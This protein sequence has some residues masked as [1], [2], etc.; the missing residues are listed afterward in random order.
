MAFNLP[1]YGDCQCGGKHVLDPTTI[2]DDSD[3]SVG[4]VE[5]PCN[6]D[7]CDWVASMSPASFDVAVEASD[8]HDIESLRAE[9][10][11]KEVAA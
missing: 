1:T 8:A 6:N 4:F 7:D 2:P 9:A 5:F 10:E 11:S 3:S